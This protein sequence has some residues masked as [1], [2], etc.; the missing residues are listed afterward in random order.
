MQFRV[1]AGDTILR[2]HLAT[3]LRNATYTSATI[4]N[5]LIDIIC[6]QNQGKIIDKVKSAKWFTVIAVEVTD[7][8][9]KELLSLVL[10]Y[11]DCDTGLV[12]EDLTRFVECDTGMSG[13]CLAKKIKITLQSYGLDLMKLR[14]Q[15]DDG[16]GNKAGSVRGTA[17]LVTAQYPLALNLHCASHCLNLAVVKS[18][19]VTSVRNLLGVVDRVYVFFAAHPKRQTALEKAIA[20][21]KPESSITKLKDLCRTRWI[22]R[23]DALQVFQSRHV[24]VVSCM[25]GIYSDGPRL[26][27]SDCC[28]DARSLQLALS[29]T[30]FGSSLVITTSC[31]QYLQALTTNLQCEAKD[32]VQAVQDSGSVKAALHNVRS[33]IDDQDN[34]WFQTVEQ[35]CSD[36]GVEPSL[37]RRCG[38]QIQRTNVPA[39]TPSTYYCRSQENAADY[40]V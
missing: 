24:S 28:T 3:G 26:R 23:I 9:N 20:E 18:L 25:E 14:G 32:I 19:Q 36:I 11:V 33:I 8:S 17:A 21:T 1:A 31:L 34:H 7:I 39:H 22:Q 38:R 37:P 16:A 13:H 29:T 35:M 27:S 40:T 10:R 6:S 4:Q 15:G 12:R 2:E 5:Q 30:D